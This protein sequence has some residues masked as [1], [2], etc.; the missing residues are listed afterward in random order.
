MHMKT[1]SDSKKLH[2][3]TNA[4]EQFKRVK[5]KSIRQQRAW[6]LEKIR[7]RKDRD[8]IRAHFYIKGFA[9]I[10]S[11]LGLT[12][13][14]TDLYDA[15]GYEEFINL[16]KSILRLNDD[17]TINYYHRLIKYLDENAYEIATEGE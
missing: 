10:V 5:Q 2:D 4:I 9:D 6:P 7:Q 8:R 16:V 15:E 13:H 1:K 11:I 14:E 17:E 3:F 12:K